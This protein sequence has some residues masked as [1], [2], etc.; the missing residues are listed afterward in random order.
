MYIFRIRTNRRPVDCQLHKQ[1]CPVACDQKTIQAKT[2]LPVTKILDKVMVLG[3]LSC[4][5][6][7]IEY[8]FDI[9][10]SKKRHSYHV[11]GDQETYFY[12]EPKFGFR[13]LIL[14]HVSYI[15]IEIMKKVS[16]S[17]HELFMPY[18]S[19][20]QHIYLALCVCNEWYTICG[21]TVWVCVG[22]GYKLKDF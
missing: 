19:W 22:G 11:T 12:P 20:L 3:A 9:S 21:L 4:H 10:Q 1:L 8:D 14:Q 2:N 17:C 7:H 16:V 5:I 18:E 15:L 13:L 6:W